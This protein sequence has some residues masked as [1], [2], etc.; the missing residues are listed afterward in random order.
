LANP[1]EIQQILN[2]RFSLH[3]ANI[4]VP[5]NLYHIFLVQNIWY[6]KSTIKFVPFYFGTKNVVQNGAMEMRQGVGR[7]YSSS[8]IPLWFEAT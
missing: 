8:V 3:E 4:F 5:G 2:E 1:E 6:K 7:V